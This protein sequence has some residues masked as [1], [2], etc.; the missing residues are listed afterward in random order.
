LTT[1]T[2]LGGGFMGA[3]HARCYSA[4]GD[5]VRVKTVCSRPS[6]R[7][8]AVADSLGA[9]LI[10]DIGAAVSDPDV[11]A[12]DICLPTHLHR[13]ATEQALAAGKHVLLEKP[14]ALTAEDAQ[15][16]ID[17]AARSERVLMVGLVLRFWPEYVELRR[18]L[19]DGEL[20]RPLAVST[21]RLSPPVDWNDWMADESLSGGVAVD[22]LVHDLDQMNALLGRPKRVFAHSPTTGHVVAAVEYE[23]GVRGGAEASMVMPASYPFS[24][25]IRVLAEGGVAE[26]AFSA[27]PAEDGGNIGTPGSAACL[28][29]YP[30]EGES[31]RI[32]VES[33]DPWAPE[34]A[35]FV[36]CIEQARRPVE[37]TAEQARDALLVSL[38]VN[39]SLRSGCGEDVR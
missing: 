8:H 5:R 26:Y 9:E 29:V 33:G 34:I 30:R 17:A 4:L 18:L 35:A 20:G 1:I 13:E 11:D 19:R 15:G 12:V 31:R 24:S 2:I 36:D 22:L 32:A 14:I 25:N 3:A 21:Y 37:G 16:I 23:G 7:S 39:R 38:A 27:A 6:A 28:R 10:E